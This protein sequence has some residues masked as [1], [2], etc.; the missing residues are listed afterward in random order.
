MTTFAFVVTV[1]LVLW[2]MARVS[3]V[4]QFVAFL[5]PPF[6]TW[7]DL[8]LP[9]VSVILCLRGNDP[10]LSP[11]L[12]ALLQQNYPH[13][14]LQIVVDSRQDPAW[15]ILMQTLDSHPPSNPATIVQVHSLEV[16]FTTC[17]LKCQSLIQ[18]ISQLHAD[19]EAI[20]ILDTDI[21]PYPNLL[22]DLVKPLGQTRLGRPIGATTGYR[23]YLPEHR[24]WGAW[25]RHVW[26]A[27]SVVQMAL[28]PPVF[29][30][31]GCCAISIK[32]LQQA[33]LL[34]CWQQSLSEDTLM[35][36]AFKTHGIQVHPVPWM[37]MLNR[38]DTSLRN[39]FPWVQRQLL[40]P[41]LYGDC[42]QWMMKGTVMNLTL[43]L[44]AIVGFIVSVGI[45]QWT[46]ALCFSGGLIGYG[47]ILLWLFIQMEEAVRQVV[48]HQ[49]EELP[50]LSEKAIAQLALVI[51]PTQWIVGI[52]MFFTYRVKK[53][54]WRGITYCLNNSSDISFEYQPYQNPGSLPHSQT[55]MF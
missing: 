45:Q 27:M 31:G 8:P 9:K 41:K 11:C 23:W 26:N 28:L 37:M 12:E 15:E 16:K 4:N 25:V 52:A 29:P 17:S 3:L 53:I 1:C 36:A 30:W 18:V 5:R 35:D 10:F 7:E 44:L 48:R 2:A 32:A 54:Q 13:Y 43:Q 46:A 22:N 24:Q 6:S 21:I 19:I 39:F 42:W 40:M 50:P 20:V 51:L 33:N 14:E 47:F 38:E 34:Q 55:S 49:G